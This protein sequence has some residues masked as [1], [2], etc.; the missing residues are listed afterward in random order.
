MKLHHWEQ[1][2][3]GWLVDNLIVILSH[4]GVGED[5]G[6]THQL[7]VATTAV[8]LQDEV[9]TLGSDHCGVRISLDED[10][11]VAWF[12]GLPEILHV[13]LVESPAD[14]VRLVHV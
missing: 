1:G 7:L 5:G 13:D 2:L 14:V 10:A 11:H 12:V 6:L 3:D 4:D 8:E 9:A